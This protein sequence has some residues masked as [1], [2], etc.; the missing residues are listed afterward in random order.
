MPFATALA[1]RPSLQSSDPM[2]VNQPMQVE[3]PYE[4]DHFAAAYDGFDWLE[5][6]PWGGSLIWH[7]PSAPRSLRRFPYLYGIDEAAGLAVLPSADDQGVPG[8][9]GLA[10]LL[11]G[12]RC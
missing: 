3:T 5:I 7:E 8:F 10:V 1:S 4:G 12:E 6:F 11:R 2:H 9:P